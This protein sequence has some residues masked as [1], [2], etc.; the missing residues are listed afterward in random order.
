MLSG[1]PVVA[2][3]ERGTINV[4]RGDNGGFMVPNDADIFARRIL[5][6]LGDEYLYEKKVADALL[7][8]KN[9]TMDIM[10][11]RLEN[12][13]TEAIADYKKERE[14]KTICID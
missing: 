5:D 4:M 2:V 13:Y 3:G 8:G 10:V 1:I 7:Y 12:I 14:Q 6:L 11:K 9:W